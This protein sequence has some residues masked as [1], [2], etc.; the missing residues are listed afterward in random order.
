MSW[1]VVFSFEILLTTWWGFGGDAG[2]LGVCA[3]FAYAMFFLEAVGVAQTAARTEADVGR[4]AVH[5]GLADFLAALDEAALQWGF[6]IDVDAAGEAGKENGKKE[7]RQFACHG[8]SLCDSTCFRP[9]SYMS[10]DVCIGH[11]FTFLCGRGL[12]CSS[13]NNKRS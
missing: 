2:A 12:T 7:K 11:V 10:N 1:P 9:K 8:S 5:A 4:G 13:P 6:F 3:L